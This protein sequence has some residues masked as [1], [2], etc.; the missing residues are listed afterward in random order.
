MSDT[1]EASLEAY[2]VCVDELESN[3][4]GLSEADLN[5]GPID[6]WTIRQIV[7]HLA[8]GDELWKTCI[9][10]ALGN[11]GAEFH[12]DWYWGVRQDDW[13]E[14]WSYD[15]RDIGTALSR[16]RVNR[17]HIVE[18][19]KQRPEAWNYVARIHWPSRPV[20][21][22]ISIAEVVKMQTDHMLNH[23]GDILTILKAEYEREAE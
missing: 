5:Q 19:L 11:P 8:D 14:Q 2:T 7:H 23:L 21:S 1:M 4:H 6:G 9:L 20:E 3:L 13:A 15:R 10:L 18:L 17:Q 22:Q 12:L 16:L